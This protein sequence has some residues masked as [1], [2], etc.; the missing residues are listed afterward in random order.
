MFIERDAKKERKVIDE[1]VS[2]SPELA[3]QHDL[4]L[5]EM[6]FKQE[7]ITARK[8]KHLTQ[9]DISELSGLSQ[10]AVSRLEKEMAGTSKR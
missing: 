7:L 10:Q 9:N 2:Q 4:F 5:Q 6:E 8:N 1:L 3:K